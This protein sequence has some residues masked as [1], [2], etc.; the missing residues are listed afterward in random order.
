MWLANVALLVP[1]TYDTIL[2]KLQ[3]S[4]VGAAESCSGNGNNTCGV[5]W[6]GGKW[7]G[8]IGMEEDISA[9]NVFSV[10]MLPFVNKD[11]KKPVSSATG[12]DSKSDP[13]AGKGKDTGEP[14]YAPITTGDKAGAGILT[15]VFVGAVIGAI[16]FM[17][18]GA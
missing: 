4:A 18:T 10:A 16:V 6:Y 17:F 5:R 8:K 11:T 1:S 12:G 7:D 3:S 14:V 9:T 15:V 13:N 2:P